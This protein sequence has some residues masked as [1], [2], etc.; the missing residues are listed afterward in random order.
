MNSRRNRLIGL[1]TAVVVAVFIVPALGLPY[2]GIDFLQA[3]TYYATAT[4][5]PTPTPSSGGGGGGGGTTTGPITVANG[6]GTANSIL[7]GSDLVNALNTGG[8]NDQP[9]AATFSVPSGSDFTVVDHNVA[10]EGH[11]GSLPLGAIINFAPV[12][13][14]QTVP[15]SPGPST[16]LQ[17]PPP[18]SGL[19]ARGFAALPIPGG[20][21][22]YSPNGTIFD[23]AVKDANGGLL[24]TFPTA[25]TVVFRYN[26]ADLAQ[27]QGNA[28]VLTAAYLIDANSPDIEN[29]NHYP[30][31]TWVFFAP[32][33]T[34]LDTTA[35]T[36]AVNTQAIGSTLT[37]ITN[38]VGY[39]Q[40]LTPNTPE[41]SSFD[42]ATSQTFGT[43]PQFS[44]LQVTE[45]QIGNRLLVLDPDTGNYSYVN[46]T[47]VGPSG[48][49][50]HQT[51]AATTRGALVTSR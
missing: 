28:S 9:V 49:P 45:P 51:A 12:P 11:A 18:A 44:Y 1:V 32:S 34:T 13:N 36:V 31:G 40:T 8:A 29:P 37:V 14:V 30:V 38:P 46:A 23:V 3:Q 17:P 19:F 41:A 24:T 5:T 2:T 6:Q 43:K 33:V 10:V 26:A 20:P 48:A 50:P 21:A 4:D 27:A 35:G 7:T 42:P 39:V 15:V 25:L 16:L 22:Q 47:D